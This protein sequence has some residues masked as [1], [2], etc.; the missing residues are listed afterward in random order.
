MK[1]V[2]AEDY[3]TILALTRNY[4]RNKTHLETGT[5]MTSRQDCTTW[6]Y[7]HNVFMV[8]P[9]SVLHANSVESSDIK[10]FM[11]GP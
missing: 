3:V 5:K 6:D 2:Y 10:V 4:K 9:N 7:N 11:V 1:M 8:G